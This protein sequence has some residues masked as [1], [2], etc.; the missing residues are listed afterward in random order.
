MLPPSLGELYAKPETG[1]K[2][3]EN[4]R[5]DES[6]ILFIEEATRTQHFCQTWYEQRAGRITGSVIGSIFKV[7]LQNPNTNLVKR[8]CE[9]ELQL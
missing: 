8:S 1:N 6:D 7:S 3:L 4:I 5:L 2:L 9:L